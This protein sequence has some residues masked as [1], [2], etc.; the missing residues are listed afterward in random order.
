MT[1]LFQYRRQPLKALYQ[2]YSVFYILGAIPIWLV[3]ALVP[4]ARPRRGW[5]VSRTLAVRVISAASAMMYATDFSVVAVDVEKNA[6]EADALGFV[7]VDPLREDMVRGEVAKMAKEND[8]KP[9]RVSGYWHGQKNK[10][11]K[12][13]Q[14]A[15]AGEKVFYALHSG[16]YVVSSTICGYFTSLTLHLSLIRPRPK[17]PALRF[18]LVFLSTARTSPSLGCSQSTTALPLRLPLAPPMLSLLR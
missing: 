6:R 9:V 8:I 10:E 14:Q 4:A 13:G 12:V 5:P 16:G 15:K 11:G 17:A 1:G 3:Q 18:T 2:L 7:W